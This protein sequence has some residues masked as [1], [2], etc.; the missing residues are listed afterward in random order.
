MNNCKQGET[1]S[2]PYASA[3]SGKN[4]REEILKILKR[5][6]CQSVGFMDEFETHSLLLAFT[7]GGRSIQLRA[8]AAGWASAYMK[9]K[10]YTHRTRVTR[11]DYEN[12][13]LAQGVIAINSI[14][15]DW[16]KGQVTAVE[17]GIL[18]FDHVFMPYMLLPNGMTLVEH[19]KSA[20]LLPALEAQ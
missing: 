7:W 5:F 18:S 12:A 6:N 4:A 17:T 19:V 13:A 1:M 14:L 3:T 16:V 2:L 11:R 8:S 10:P 20:G 9:D 15:R